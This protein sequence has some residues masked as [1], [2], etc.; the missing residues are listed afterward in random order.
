MFRQCLEG[1]EGGM[2]RIVRPGVTGR[3]TTTVPVQSRR[4]AGGPRDD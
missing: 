2:K 1:L 3:V 4:A